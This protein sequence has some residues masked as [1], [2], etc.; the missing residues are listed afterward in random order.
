MDGIDL[1]VDHPLTWWFQWGW[2]LMQCGSHCPVVVDGGI[3]GAGN[4]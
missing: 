1:L 3:D 4:G 2:F